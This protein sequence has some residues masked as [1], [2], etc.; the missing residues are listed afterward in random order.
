[1]LTKE[2]SLAI[3]INENTQERCQAGWEQK[4]ETRDPAADDCAFVKS[5]LC[6]LTVIASVSAVR[7]NVEGCFSLR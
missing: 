3:Y 7:A 5:L 4:V 6:K 1:M 2:Y